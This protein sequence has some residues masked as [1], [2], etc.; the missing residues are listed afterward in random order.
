MV[1]ALAG[2]PNRLGLASPMH[3]AIKV[4][5]A[6]FVVFRVFVSASAAYVAIMLAEPSLGADWAGLVCG[7]VFVVTVTMTDREIN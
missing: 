6:A 3:T 7:V 2:S 4:R 1:L 5:K